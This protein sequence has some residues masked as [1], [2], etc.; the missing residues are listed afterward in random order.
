VGEA[1]LNRATVQRLLHRFVYL[2]TD[3]VGDELLAAA[4]FGSVA[5]DEAREGSDL[6]VLVVVERE[7]REVGAALVRAQLALRRSVEY[8]A[9]GDRSEA[10]DVSLLMLD[11]R[12]L[13]SHPW[14]LM[15]VALDGIVLVDKAGLLE[16]ELEAVRRRMAELGSRRVPLPDG[17]WYWDVKPG[18]RP[19]EAIAL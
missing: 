8:L 4:L 15:D 19:G 6:D 10:P 5:R 9:L 3:E 7:R 14:I 2:A 13:S 17:R 1:T 16:R 11:R 18:S 12:R